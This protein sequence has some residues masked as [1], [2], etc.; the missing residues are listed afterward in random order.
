MKLQGAGGG[1]DAGE[2]V[3]LQGFAGSH[4]YLPCKAAGGIASQDRRRLTFFW[5][6]A[7]RRRIHL[8]SLK[9]V[10]DVLRVPAARPGA[11]HFRAE[12]SVA[13]P[14][15]FWSASSALSY[16]CG[17]FLPY[18]PTRTRSRAYSFFFDSL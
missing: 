6:G 5:G 18:G 15:T 9:S 8:W 3:K 2:P 4:T 13:P 16:L 1:E 12:L 17:F 10:L 14:L 7:E 11:R